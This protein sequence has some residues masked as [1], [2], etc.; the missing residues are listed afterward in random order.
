MSLQNT[1]AA[2]TYT[3]CS[4][5]YADCQ[6]DQAV[7]PATGQPPASSQ[8]FG[9]SD[10]SWPDLLP[11]CLPATAA[12]QLTGSQV[13]L[14]LPASYV[15]SSGAYRFMRM[16]TR[17]SGPVVDYDFQE[18]TECAD[19]V[20]P[21]FNGYCDY[22]Q[23]ISRGSY[24]PPAYNN[25]HYNLFDTN[26]SYSTMFA[27]SK[28]GANVVSGC[29]ASFA[30]SQLFQFFYSASVP[31]NAYSQLVTVTPQP[32]VP[33]N[34]CQAQGYTSC[35]C[36]T[37]LTIPTGDGIIKTVDGVAYTKDNV[38]S[39]FMSYSLSS[40]AIGS[41]TCSPAMVLPYSKHASM[42]D[43]LDRLASTK[44][45]PN[46][47]NCPSVSGML[48]TIIYTFAS[49]YNGFD[50]PS[51]SYELAFPSGAS[52]SLPDLSGQPTCKYLMDWQDSKFRDLAL[53]IK[54]NTDQTDQASQTSSGS[55]NV[56]FAQTV[57]D[58]KNN[59][60]V[61]SFNVAGRLPGCVPTGSAS[62]PT[63]ASPYLATKLS[64]IFVVGART[65]SG[66][67]LFH[68]GVTR[69][70]GNTGQ[71]GSANQQ[72]NT[73]VPEDGP[74][75]NKKSD[76]Y[77]SWPDLTSLRAN[78]NNTWL[79]DITARVVFFNPWLT[80]PVRSVM[81][82]KLQLTDQAVRQFSQNCQALFAQNTP[83][84]TT[85]TACDQLYVKIGRAHV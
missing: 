84:W 80:D 64:D 60:F 7:F 13:Y 42:R 18:D 55:N 41:S 50:A 66:S 40:T 34:S 53:S 4:Q 12:K 39:N 11:V 24:F 81:D 45:V 14:V 1:C 26:V 73:Y 56:W 78:T 29:D 30:P 3:T 49:S 72:G 35:G 54:V 65:A 2:P 52:C 82:S 22:T 47:D 32:T 51:S 67:K 58:S 77:A 36:N 21:W 70:L 6:A 31:L 85:S 27:S 9:G 15:D 28:T 76:D 33:S 16:P 79:V 25:Q 20:K 74:A 83:N 62:L 5:P 75:W 38:T 10:T 8:S 57:A 59:L 68:W 61:K 23:I 19:T 37:Y 44:Q 17:P 71:P 48:D 63:S 69:N 43:G 46:E